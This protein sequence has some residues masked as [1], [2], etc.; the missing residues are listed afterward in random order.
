MDEIEKYANTL[1]EEEKKLFYGDLNV[2][3]NHVLREESKR[4]SKLWKWQTEFYLQYLQLHTQW[5]TD[6]SGQN[7]SFYC[8]RC[9]IEFDPESENLRKESKFVVPDRNQEAAITSV[10]TTPD[11]SIIHEPQLKGGFAALAKKGTIR[12]PS[13]QESNP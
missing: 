6:S 11:V 10:D 2:R 7:P 4:L 1:N 3:W 5:L 13:Y 12:F 8:T 9:N